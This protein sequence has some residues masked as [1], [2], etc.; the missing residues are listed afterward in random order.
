MRPNEVLMY[1]ISLKN[2]ENEKSLWKKIS[3]PK[4]RNKHVQVKEGGLYKEWKPKGNVQ[5]EA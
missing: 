1:K 5:L 3:S 2:G 4:E